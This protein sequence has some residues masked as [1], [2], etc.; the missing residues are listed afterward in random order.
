MR[1][2]IGRKEKV[3]GLEFMEIKRNYQSDKD[4]LDRNVK[5]MMDIKNTDTRR[6]ALIM[7]DFIDCA[8]NMR[9]GNLC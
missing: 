9:L 2:N 6:K 4:C 3:Q 7:F 5:E 1:V 8:S